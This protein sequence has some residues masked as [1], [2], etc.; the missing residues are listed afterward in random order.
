MLH[1]V[2]EGCT[3]ICFFFVVFFRFFFFFFLEWEWGRVG[4]GSRVYFL[5]NICQCLQVIL[6]CLPEKGRNRTEEL[7]LD[8]LQSLATKYFSHNPV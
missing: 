8:W 6:C 4:W 2:T 7:A 3:K 1:K 5:F